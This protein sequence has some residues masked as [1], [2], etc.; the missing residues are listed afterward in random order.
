[1]EKLLHICP[2]SPS[3]CA[4]S[5]SVR[6]KPKSLWE[7]VRIGSALVCCELVSYMSVNLLYLYLVGCSFDLIALDLFSL[8]KSLI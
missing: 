5:D 7:A 6:L 2:I 4:G 3:I 1:M 8:D